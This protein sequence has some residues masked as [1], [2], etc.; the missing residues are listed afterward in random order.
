[1]PRPLLTP[2]ERPG[3]HFTEGWLG[4]R[5]GVERCGKLKF[6]AIKFVT[7]Q[8]LFIVGKCRKK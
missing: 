6:F 1:M 5:A 3:T 8:M 7:I 4:P 2:R